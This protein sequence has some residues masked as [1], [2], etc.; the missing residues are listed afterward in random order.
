MH[1]TSSPFSTVRPAPHHVA[2]T[3]QSDDQILRVLM[4]ADATVRVLLLG[5]LCDGDVDRQRR[6]REMVE[7]ALSWRAQDQAGRMKPGV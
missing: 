1:L 2:T 7:A 4:E 6:L 5:H 3:A